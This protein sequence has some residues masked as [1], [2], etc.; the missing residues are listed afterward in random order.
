MDKSYEKRAAQEAAAENLLKEADMTGLKVLVVEDNDLNR[1]IANMLLS[2]EG[3]EVEEA[4]NGQEAV[5]KFAAAEDGH[6]DIVFMDIMMPVMDGLEAT[7]QIRALDR[8]DAKTTLIIAMSANAFQD[9]VERCLEAGMDA[10]CAKPF[11]I[12][13]V[14]KTIWQL[15]QAR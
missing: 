10:H 9:D 5:D 12:S 4:V 15:M 11:E 2:Y 3:A 6:Y 1:E 8:P 13:R 14:K 7:R